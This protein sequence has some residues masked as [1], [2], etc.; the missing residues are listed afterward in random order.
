MDKDNTLTNQEFQIL[1]QLLDSGVRATGIN[2][3][4]GGN[5]LISAMQKFFAMKPEE[6]TEENK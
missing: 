2:I 1:A 4:A 3:A 6:K 5:D